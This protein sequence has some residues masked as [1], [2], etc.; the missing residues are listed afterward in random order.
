MNVQGMWKGNLF[1]NA[2][3]LHATKVDGDTPIQG[4]TMEG[5]VEAGACPE[6]DLTPASSKLFMLFYRWMI[7]W[8]HC[9]WR[10]LGG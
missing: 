5:V 10:L 9:L 7:R 4:G 8:D 2:Q 6:A 1:G 3:G